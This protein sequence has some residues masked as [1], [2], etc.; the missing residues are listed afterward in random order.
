MTKPPPTPLLLVDD[1]PDYC[2][3]LQ[4]F[5]EL[6]NYMVDVAYAPDQALTKLAEG[7]YDIAVVAW[8]SRSGP[9]NPACR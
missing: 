4:G 9:R 8:M 5:L 7:R 1:D 3:S 6:E 2:H